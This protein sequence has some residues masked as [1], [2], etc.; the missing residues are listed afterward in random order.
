MKIYIVKHKE[1]GLYF[2]GKLFYYAPTAHKYNLTEKE[3]KARVFKALN[4]LKSA[5]KI[6]ENFDTDWEIITKECI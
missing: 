2:K 5:F 4:H 6:A 1:T 3:Q